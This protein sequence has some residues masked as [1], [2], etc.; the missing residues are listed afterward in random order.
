ETAHMWFGNLV[1]MRWFNDV[2]TK[3]VF[4]NF[5]ADKIVNPQFPDT[6][7]DLNFLVSHYPQAYGVDRSEG[8]N[9]IRQQLDNLNLAGQMY[10]PIIYH[11]APIMM[12]QL[13][14]LL[15]ETAFRDGLRSYLD[16]FSYA[17]ATWPGLIEI[18]DE[19]TT[20]DLTAWSE[21]WVNTQGMPDFTLAKE[22]GKGSPWVLQQ[23]DP[24]GKGREWPQ[25][26]S[27]LSLNEASEVNML[28][29][30][31]APLP[32]SVQD[33]SEGDLL[34]NA[35]GL[36]YGRFPVSDAIFDAWQSLTPLQRGVMLVSSFEDLLA[37]NEKSALN[38]LE[39][40]ETVL[41]TEGNDLLIELAASQ[42]RYVYFSLLTADQR[43]ARRVGLENSLWQTIDLQD[44]PSK[45]K[46]FFEIY[47]GLALSKPALERV[48]LV[49]S[50]DE[51]IENLSLQEAEKIRLA[52]IL[53]VRLPDQANVIIAAQREQTK[54]PDRLRRL[55]FLAPAL[56]PDSDIRDAFFESLSDPANRATEVWV[57]DALRRL[58]DPT[59]LN[60]S[61]RYVL[62]SLKLLEEIQVTGD[63]FFP[64]AWLNRTLGPHSATEVAELVR[65][66]LA[67]RPDYNPQLRM[68]ILQAADPL[69]HASGRK[70]TQPSL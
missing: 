69:F 53:A 12:R 9:P 17:N 60:H 1:T 14:L 21:V 26:F 50:G 59:R 61:A 3:E 30:R 42:L 38:Y 70:N 20:I 33:A 66:F 35:N 49:W 58:H 64:S 23:L 29:A 43:D 6:D 68:K 62:P 5:M 32:E 8:A 45:T 48:R 44:T 54:N 28:A 34:L 67:K 25:Q 27:V 41:M 52:E 47:S 22:N 36:G 39:R 15:G 57:S 46:R 18:L 56:S 10:G 16:R 63:I 19:K 24:Q 2:W 7:H 4:A 13:E 31:N 51:V 11:K 65:E 40:L 37:N 55:N